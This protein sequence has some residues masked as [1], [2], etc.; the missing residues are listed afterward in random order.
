MRKKKLKPLKPSL[1][2]SNRYITIRVRSIDKIKNSQAVEKAIYEKFTEL[3]GVIK[4]AE[5]G[6]MVV[7][8]TWKKDEQTGILKVNKKFADQAKSS[9][10]FVDK[11]NDKDAQVTSIGTSGVINKAIMLLN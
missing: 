4:A 9:L 11:I 3:F 2:E 7:S 10:L 1:R 8:N 5:S 6:L